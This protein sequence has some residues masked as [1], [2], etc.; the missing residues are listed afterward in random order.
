MRPAR[1]PGQGVSSMLRNGEGRQQ[2]W[3][4]PHPRTFPRAVNTCEAGRDPDLLLV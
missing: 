2:G 1:R 4:I 3:V